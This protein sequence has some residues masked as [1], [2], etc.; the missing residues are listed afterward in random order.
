[1]V[2]KK[3]KCP[4]CNFSFNPLFVFKIK[5]VNQD[6][7][8]PN[9]KT[10]LIPVMNKKVEKNWKFGFLIGLIFSVIPAQ[11]YLMFNKNL[12]KGLSIGLTSGL[13]IL[14]IVVYIVFKTTSFK[15]K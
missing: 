3:F 6:I 2:S 12:L 4:N 13:I 7:I 9:C 8:C 11:T 1:M 10:T 15:I 14:S 5:N